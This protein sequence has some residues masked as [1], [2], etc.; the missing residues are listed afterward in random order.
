MKRMMMYLIISAMVAMMTATT[1]WATEVNSAQ[2]YYT[3]TFRPDHTC[4]DDYAAWTEVMRQDIPIYNPAAHGQPEQWIYGA[5]YSTEGSSLKRC[6]TPVQIQR[7]EKLRRA[8]M[9][10]ELS[11]KGWDVSRMKWAG[12]QSWMAGG[13]IMRIYP[14][15]SPPPK[16]VT[17]RTVQ[18]PVDPEDPT[19]GKWAWTEIYNPDNPDE[20]L[21]AWPHPKDGRPGEGA[22]GGGAGG[23]MWRLFADVQ[24]TY[25]TYPLPQEE[26]R[27][28]TYADQEQ[29]E[30]GD[31]VDSLDFLLGVEFVHPSGILLRVA[32][33]VGVAH[34][35]TTDPAVTRDTG[36][37]NFWGFRALGELGYQWDSGFLVLLGS[38]FAG[39]RPNDE[40][41]SSQGM[42]TAP[43]VGVGYELAL[44][45]QLGLRP[46]GK[47][48]LP[49]HWFQQY[50][51]ISDVKWGYGAALIGGLE[52]I[53]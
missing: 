37:H 46:Y 43:H 16:K 10:Q 33:G 51:G 13:M 21:S 50:P 6:P 28:T 24:Y 25:V 18:R 22:E 47:L 31:D 36:Q 20:V 30:E 5:G 53:W 9:E 52:I 14:G 3:V 32:L 1:V 40:W 7:V 26:K 11:R 35:T 19:K 49:I 42:L 45:S 27:F 39:L 2:A 12:A 41:D 29:L 15:E 38:Q 48:G 17:A 34:I 4:A 44:T 23:S 8:W